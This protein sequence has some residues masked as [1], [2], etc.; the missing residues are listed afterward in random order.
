MTETTIVPQATYTRAQAAKIITTM[1]L[2]V[3]GAKS[4][5]A[6]YAPFDDVAAEHWAAGYIAFCK[7]QGIIDGVTD[8]TFDPEGTLTGYQ[9]AKMLLAAVGFNANNELEGASWSLNTARIGHEVGLFTGDSAAADHTPLRR[10]QAMLYAFNTLS[11]VRQVTWTANG[12]NY[13]YNIWG[14]EWAD[15]TGYTLGQAVFGLEG[16][17]GIIVANEGTGADYTVLSKNYTNTSTS[18]IASVVADTGLDMMYH[19]ARIWTVVDDHDTIG[20]SDDELVSVYVYDLATVTEYTCG[21]I[22]KAISDNASKVV[23]SNTL[24]DSK[25]QTSEVYEYALIDNTAYNA[26]SYAGISFVYDIGDLGVTDSLKDTTVID[27]N[28]VD[29]DDIWT[30]LSGMSRSDTVIY[31]VEGGIYYVYATS[32]TTGTIRGYDNATG[33]V[34]LTDGTELAESVFYDGDD[35]ETNNITKMLGNT[36]TFLLDTHGHYYDVTRTGVANLYFYTGEFQVTSDFG[37]Y[38]GEHTYSAQFFNVETGE[39]VDLPVTSSFIID[40]GTFRPVGFYDLGVADE[41]GIYYPGCDTDTGFE[42]YEEVTKDDNVYA[43]RY[44][45]SGPWGLTLQPNSTTVTCGGTNVRLD[46]N[47]TFIV[48]SGDGSDVET[49]PYDSLD[50]LFD[51]YDG[52]SITFYTAAITTEY[53][54]TGT[55]VGTVVFGYVGDVTTSGSY[56]FLPETIDA[57]DWKVEYVDGSTQY[58]YTGF[59]LNGAPITVTVDGEFN[60]NRSAGFYNFTVKNGVWEIERTG[61]NTY[62]GYVDVDSD[63]SGTRVW[64]DNTMVADNAIV[65]DCRDGVTNDNAINTVAKLLAQYDAKSVK[66]AYSLNSSNEA[67]VIY[68]VEEGF[69]SKTTVS[70]DR[71]L[72]A[73]GWTF[74]N[75]E[76]SLEYLDDDIVPTTYTLVNTNDVKLDSNAKYEV[77]K[78]INTASSTANVT[79]DEDGNVVVSFAGDDISTDNDNNFNVAITIS[80]L[81]N[82]SPISFTSGSFT[83]VFVDRSTESFEANGYV[84]GDDIYVDVYTMNA[85]AG[86]YDLTFTSS[87]ATITVEDVYLQANGHT[88]FTVNAVRSGTYTLTN[89]VPSHA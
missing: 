69:A 70:L 45:V 33:T 8:T 3:N 56:L 53:S 80:G 87:N 5:V 47:V 27:G 19:A 64:L 48:A 89:C 54:S 25:T 18:R 6:S 63:T 85:T 68:V 58:Y 86:Y 35:F 29:N 81:K 67:N 39:P 62:I 1:V 28:T 55:L 76:T 26:K 2:G 84:Y 51:A 15:G 71:S 7:E 44:V 73:A 74:D 11:A 23:F 75:G 50:A 78:T 20:T 77:T 17:T 57:S 60:K 14:Y 31:I 83:T 88:S 24:G 42:R 49:V 36:F 59:Y 82:A 46:A 37:A 13:V 30:S 16:Y 21:A 38:H 43:D 72:I 52:N 4:C 12:D 10:E 9:W 65:V 79:F 32:A 66:L 22:K 61:L 40:N 41:N 34:T